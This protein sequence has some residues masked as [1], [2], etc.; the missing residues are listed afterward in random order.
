MHTKETV[1]CTHIL[2]DYDGYEEY[3]IECG[4]TKLPPRYDLEDTEILDIIGWD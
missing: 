4:S 3:C 1:E 2:T